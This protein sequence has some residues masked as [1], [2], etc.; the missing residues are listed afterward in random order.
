[1]ILCPE[2]GA[3]RLI[4]LTFPLYRRKGAQPGQPELLVRPV[5]KCTSCGVRVFA[6]ILASKRTVK[7]TTKM[8][9]A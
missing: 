8:S 4:P 1:L 9:G 2:C 3:D 7:P 5:A 6:N